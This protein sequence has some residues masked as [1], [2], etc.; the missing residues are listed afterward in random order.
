MY[1]CIYVCRERE[2]ATRLRNMRTTIFSASQERL[3]PSICCWICCKGS[4]QNAFIKWLVISFF[5][6]GLLA[7]YSKQKKMILLIS[8]EVTGCHTHETKDGMALEVASLSLSLSLCLSVSLCR[9][10]PRSLT[11][12]LSFSLSRLSR[13]SHVYR[14]VRSIL[15]LMMRRHQGD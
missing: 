7:A 4:P 3:A 6:C 1:V 8:R 5:C 10:L 15:W 11:L 2:R 14:V 12:S 13:A 9:S